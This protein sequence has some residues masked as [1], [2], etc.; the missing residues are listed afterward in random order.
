MNDEHLAKNAQNDVQLVRQIE[1]KR[2]PSGHLL[3]H[4]VVPHRHLMF[5]SWLG[6]PTRHQNHQEISKPMQ[7]VRWRT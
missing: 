4:F 6:L 1:R 5:N 7:P 3:V 2:S